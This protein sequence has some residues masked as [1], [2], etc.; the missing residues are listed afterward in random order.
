LDFIQDSSSHGASLERSKTVIL[1]KN[2]PFDTT[3]LEVRNLFQ[4]FGALGRVLIPP[5]KTIAIVEFLEA[6]E[7]R[8]AFRNL[9]Y[10]RFKS[11]PLFLEWAPERLFEKTHQQMLQEKATN[12]EAVKID[13]ESMVDTT[14][15]SNPNTVY[16]KN[17]NFSTTEETL[18]S[19]IE[20]KGIGEVRSI[21]IA[22]KKDL[23]AGGALKSIGYGFVE[24]K[25]KE[26]AIRFISI[27]QGFELEG[28]V[29]KLKL[30]S[31]VDSSA[32]SNKNST[33]ATDAASRISKK[34]APNASC[35][36]LLVKNIP[37]ESNEREIR[38]LFK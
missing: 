13:P 30:S 20:E 37:F 4:K 26:D 16:V 33:T 38:E 19:L 27:L 10:T 15:V 32:S 31:S 22:K 5:T 25:S 23:K 28:H 7:A 1:V 14:S 11:L 12:S 36:K 35:T 9:A 8:S 18:R 6:S 34:R 24:F 3:D 29:L 21:T 2:I 17:L